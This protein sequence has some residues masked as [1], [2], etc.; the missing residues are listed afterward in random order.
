MPQVLAHGPGR[1]F[2]VPRR[3]RGNDGQVLSH[4]AVKA[5]GRTDH[6]S[7]S[8]SLTDGLVEMRQV[9]VAGRLKDRVMKREVHLV[10]SLV[11]LEGRL[12]SV[13]RQLDQ[14]LV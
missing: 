3:D 5:G 8:N 9:F 13:S 11:V 14:R 7:P 6:S 10:M 12:P 1:H 2:L 4:R